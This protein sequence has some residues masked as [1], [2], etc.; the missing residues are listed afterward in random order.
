MHVP[1]RYLPYSTGTKLQDFG[2]GDFYVWLQDVPS[3]SLAEVVTPL[4]L[5]MAEGHEGFSLYRE[6]QGG[7]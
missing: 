1:G 7:V 2:G 4:Q 3:S 6:G 5:K